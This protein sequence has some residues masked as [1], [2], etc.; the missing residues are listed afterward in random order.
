MLAQDA[1]Q[2]AADMLSA[3]ERDSALQTVKASRS[4][5]SHVFLQDD[6]GK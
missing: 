3:E 6:S 5:L 4:I 2:T 1:I